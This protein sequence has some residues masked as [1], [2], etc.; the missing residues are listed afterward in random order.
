MP[1]APGGDARQMR[2]HNPLSE[3]YAPSNPHKQKAP[4]RKGRS[5][6]GDED[7]EQQAYIDSKASRKIISLGQ[8]LTA[9]EEAEQEARRPQNGTKSAFEFERSLRDE[10]DSDEEAGIPADDEAWGDEE[11]E[12][13]EE[14]EVDPED[15]AMF[16]KFN[17]EFDPS[18][19]LAPESNEEQE[20]STNLADLI[21]EKIAQHEASQAQ[22]HV[23]RGGGAPEDAIELPAKVV[24]V[25][26]QIGMILS[27]FRSGK[28]PKPFKILPTLPQWD[29]LLSITRP[30]SWTANATYEATR[31]FTS[32]RPAVAQAFIHDILLDRVR[33]DIRETK[34]LNVHLYKALKKALYKPACFFKGLLFPLLASGTCTLRE[35]HIISSVLV[36]VSIPV[37]HSAAAIHRLCEIAAEQM[38]DNLEAGG[39]TNIFIRVLL[40]KKYAL[41]YKVVDA[42]VF[43]FLRFRA[44]DA[45]A[46]T[47]A[48][49]TIKGGEKLPA[50]G[51]DGDEAGGVLGTEVADDVHGGLVHV[52]ELLGVGPAAE[53]AEGALV[54]AAADGT[55][56]AVLRSGNALEEEL[57]LGGE[58]ETVVQDLWSWSW[59]EG[60]E[61]EETYLGVVE[62]QELITESAN[63]T[64][65]GETLEIDV[66]GAQAGKTGGLV[67]A[68]RLETDEAVL[69]N[70]DT[71]NTVLAGNGVDS[72]EELGGIGD[73]LAAGELSL[74]GQTLLEVKDKVLGLLGSLGGV[75]GQLPHV[76][77]GSDVGVLE[78]TGLVTAVG[79]V[80]V[81]APGLALCA[82]DGDAGLLGVV[83]EILATLEAVVEDG[84]APW[85]NDL[86]GGLQG[87]EG[88]LEADLVVALT[89]AAVRD[90]ETALLLGDGDLGAGNDGTGERNVLVDGIALDSGPAELLDEL[91][92]EILNVALLGTNLEG[93][94][95]GSIKV[96]LLA[97]I[98]HEA[99][100][101]VA[102]VQQVLEDT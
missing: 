95:A 55:V 102:L 60:E 14:V 37:L 38:T 26:T 68:T 50:D 94:L 62:G 23:I 87:V 21:L 56:D 47:D 1:K 83:E 79:Q 22:G 69:D 45:D 71:A 9:E 77:G 51:V 12:E 13:V 86:D 2:R 43:H 3:D 54:D 25:Y 67:A 78:D 6:A 72:K 73:S 88:Q 19:L 98:G 61:C 10:E 84:V 33:D 40:E 85:G 66:S 30:D 52:V 99:D 96:L 44:V 31:L 70:V 101:A 81:H 18:T 82:G 59:V 57:A 29:T 90:S 28:L 92:A 39:A 24:E 27:R 49:A 48:P 41:P 7:N 8:D 89:G 93:L 11:D 17:P 80:L 97:N 58:V 53:D 100:D 65:H 42:V 63:L 4:K 15:L 34:K 32:S 76:L 75:D 74:D 91:L 35:A 16:N 46:M 20:D 5:T 36:R 64:V